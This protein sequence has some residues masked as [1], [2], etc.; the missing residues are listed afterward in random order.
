MLLLAR[1]HDTR[2]SQMWKVDEKLTMLSRVW[3][4]QKELAPPMRLKLVDTLLGHGGINL[5][6]H[7][8]GVDKLFRLWVKTKEDVDGS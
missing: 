4:M 5:K 6:V 1:R 7:L 8:S 3:K 2:Y